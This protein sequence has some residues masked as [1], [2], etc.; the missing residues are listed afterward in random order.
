MNKIYAG[1]II[2][3]ICAFSDALL[4][5]HPK[6]WELYEGY[7]FLFKIDGIYNTIGWLTGIVCLPLLFIGYKGVKEVADEHSARA[8][9]KSEPMV[10]MLIAM[11]GVVHSVYHFVPLFHLTQPKQLID[12]EINTIKCVEVIFVAVYT[13][14][15][16]N[17]GLQSLKVKNVLLYANRYFNPLFWMILCLLAAALIPNYGMLMMVSGFNMSIAFY[18][19]GII[20]QQKKLAR[21]NM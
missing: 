5:Y 14:F 7:A 17:I 8:L 10:V 9:S 2:A 15:V 12:V 13:V 11:G 1:L 4:L 20:I 18:F 6:L 21:K 19:T 3:L 16:V